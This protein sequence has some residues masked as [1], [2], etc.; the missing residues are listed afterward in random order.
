MDSLT[1]SE[2]YLI[3][4]LATKVKIAK[5]AQR[6][7]QDMIREHSSQVSVEKEIR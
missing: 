6:K 7:E 5:I 1:Q 4:S 3:L 2:S